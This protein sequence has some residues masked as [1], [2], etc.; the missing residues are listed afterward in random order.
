MYVDN[1][2]LAASA[3]L[4][5]EPNTPPVKARLPRPLTVE[6][7][8]ILEALASQPV[9]MVDLG[10]SWSSGWHE[11]GAK[12]DGY[13]AWRTEYPTGWH[14]AVLQG[15]HFTVA[16]PFAKNPNEQCRSK[17]DYTTWDL[18]ELGEVVV[19]RTNYQRACDR[20][21]YG[22]GLDHWDGRPF[23]DHWRLAWRRMTQPGLERSL[24]AALIPPG[25]AH[26]HTV[27]S[28][29]LRS[30]RQTA[31]V[32]GLWASLPLDYLVK[33]SGKADLSDELLKR[34]PAP[35]DHPAAPFLLLRTLRLNCLTAD[36][37]PLWGEL[38]EAGFTEDGWTPAFAHRPALG[39]VGPEWTM[40]TPLRTEFDRRAA[41]VEID[42]LAALMLGLSADQLCLM[43]RAQ[44]PVLRKY[45]YGMFFDGAG[46]KIAKEHHAAGVRQ[47]KEDYALVSAWHDDPGSV[48]LPEL[49]VAPFTKPDREAEMRAAYA[50]F[51]GRLGLDPETG[52]GA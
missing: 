14:E 33:V 1:S 27:H 2:S 31:L 5:D 36:Y 26:V 52:A 23:T 22:A 7:A 35:L 50:E 16:T 38:F 46:R 4:F 13:I 49:Y 11:K 34:F 44:F 47:G 25:P 9:R 28:L 43:Y 40:A 6:H 8:L 19:P 20:D 41:L 24:H 15:P 48:E 12:E 29:A 17:G 39:A 10:Y 3:A 51:A 30:N 21:R 37:A 45:E 18:E 42:A 32:A